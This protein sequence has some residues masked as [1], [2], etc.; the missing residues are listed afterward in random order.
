ML[1]RYPSERPPDLLCGE[2]GV[3][4]C[5]P[6]ARVAMV[7]LVV[8]VAEGAGARA[9]GPLVRSRTGQN[10]AG[11]AKKQ[12]PRPLLPAAEERALQAAVGV[13]RPGARGSPPWWPTLRSAGAPAPQRHTASW[14]LVWNPDG[15]VDRPNARV[16]RAARCPLND[17][18]WTVDGAVVAASSRFAPR[19][20]AEPRPNF[21]QVVAVW[22][23]PAGPVR[24]AQARKHA[25]P[26][27]ATAMAATGQGHCGLLKHP[28]IL[29]APG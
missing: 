5:S 10:G 14:S 4:A 22:P 20:R 12:R 1:P 7:Q 17:A 15:T 2:E 28:G 19:P 13:G 3:R 25:S 16:V 29:R 11:Y 21:R 9:G 24:A 26:A 23:G 8:L 18:A 27:A 6:P